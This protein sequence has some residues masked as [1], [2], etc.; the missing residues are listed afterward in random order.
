MQQDRGTRDDGGRVARL[1]QPPT[2]ESARLLED[3]AQRRYRTDDDLARSRTAREEIKRRAHVAAQLAEKVVA[4][5]LTADE[6]SVLQPPFGR[7][8]HLPSPDRPYAHL[9]VHIGLGRVSVTPLWATTMGGNVVMSTVENRIKV[10]ATAVDPLVALSVP[11]RIGSQ[12]SYEVGGFAKQSPDLGRELIRALARMYSNPK[13]GEQADG[14]YTSWDRREGND[15]LRLEVLAF[16]VR[17]DLGDEPLSR[18]APYV[19]TLGPRYTSIAAGRTSHDH[20]GGPAG[21]ELAIIGLERPTTG[22]YRSLNSTYGHLACFGPDGLLRCRQIGFDLLD[23]EGED[24]IAFL[25]DKRDAGVFARN[26]HAAVSIVKYRGGSVWLQSQGVVRVHDDASLL[27]AAIGRLEDRYSR[28]H[29]RL[30]L[31]LSTARRPPGDYLLATLSHQRL[32]SR[33]REAERSSRSAR[34]SSAV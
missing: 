28:A 15:R 3:A 25:V 12:I 5:P 34:E 29:Q 1:A 10:R 14:N 2:P 7:A 27:R 23:I 21:D 32:S 17:S 18:V 9:A 20:F 11:A 16:R 6:C 30:A 8:A 33:Y 24:S 19:E 13:I 22:R 4:L 26:P 31:D